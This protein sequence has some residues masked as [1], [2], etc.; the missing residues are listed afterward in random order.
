VLNAEMFDQNI[1]ILT[2]ASCAANNWFWNFMISRFTPQM[3][4]KM[5]Y[6]VY[7]FFATLMILSMPYVYFLVPETKGVPLEDMD[8]LFAKDVKPWN[9][10]GKIMAQ[11][12]QRGGLG[13]GVDVDVEEYAVKSKDFQ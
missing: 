8:K 9:A 1:R 11:I 6:G 3:F 5:G 2:Q 4:T 12:R 10:H 7:I 13:G